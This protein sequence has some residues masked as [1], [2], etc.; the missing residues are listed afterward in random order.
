MEI[1]EIK[2]KEYFEYAVVDKELMQ[3]FESFKLPRFVSE[4]IVQQF[5]E[6]H[7]FEKGVIKIEEFLNAITGHLVFMASIIGIPKPS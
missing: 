4:Y 6:E 7:G 2:L 3:K 1:W 5:I